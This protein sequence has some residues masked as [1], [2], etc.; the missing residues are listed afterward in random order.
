MRYLFKQNA[1]TISLLRS[2]KSNSVQIDLYRNPTL[3]FLNKQVKTVVKLQ[4]FSRSSCCGI[5]LTKCPRSKVKEEE[6]T[7]N[8]TIELEGNKKILLL[9]RVKVKPTAYLF[10]S[11]NIKI[12]IFSFFRKQ[13]CCSNAM[14]MQKTNEN[15]C[16]KHEHEWTVLSNYPQYSRNVLKN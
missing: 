14:K 2:V 13:R 8:V 9:S 12:R 7:G 6:C 3:Y 4:P 5:C 11:Q 10:N 1:C 15:L 16:A